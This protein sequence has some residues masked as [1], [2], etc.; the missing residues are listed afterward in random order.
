LAVDVNGTASA[1]AIAA[2]IANGGDGSTATPDQYVS[3]AR[4]LGSITQLT[5]S[6]TFATPKTFFGSTFSS[7]N[8]NLAATPDIQWGVFAVDGTN[9]YS[10]G[11]LSQLSG[12]TGGIVSGQVSQILNAAGTIAKLDASYAQ[13]TNAAGT[14]NEY[15][16]SISSTDLSNALS[17]IPQWQFGNFTTA[18]LGASQSFFKVSGVNGAV[19]TYA[20]SFSLAANGTATWTSTAVSAVPLPAAALLFGPGLLGLVA[21]ARRRRQGEV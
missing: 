4:N 9:L 18:A 11:L 8:T 1:A 17:A 5:S 10:T 14:T 6:L 13:G 12:K 2:D 20:G 16:G 7:T 15:G 19:S 21:A 3:Y